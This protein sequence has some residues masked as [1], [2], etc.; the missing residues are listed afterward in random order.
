M[1]WIEKLREMSAG[2]VDNACKRIWDKEVFG[3][4]ERHHYSGGEG[5]GEDY[6]EAFHLKDHGVYIEIAG[7]YQ[8]HNGVD[9]WGSWEDH[10]Y[11]VFPAVSLEIVYWKTPQPKESLL[12]IQKKV[13]DLLDKFK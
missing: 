10:V 8:S 2:D 5:E 9:Y 11:Q 1:N 13:S 7:N 6:R 3:E 4:V 12:E